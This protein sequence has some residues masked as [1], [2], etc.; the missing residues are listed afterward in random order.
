[1][2][3]VEMVMVDIVATM[4][5]TLVGTTLLILFVQEVALL[6]HR[7]HQIVGR[8]DNQPLPVKNETSPS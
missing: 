2:V 6:R 7:K 4:V 8:I 1:M 3:E 5:V